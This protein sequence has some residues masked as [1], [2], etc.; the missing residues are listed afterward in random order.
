MELFNQCSY[1]NQHIKFICV[2]F[3]FTNFILIPIYCIGGT[4]GIWQMIGWCNF[5]W[6]VLAIAL[7]LTYGF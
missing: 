5:I 2:C 4:K 1:L 6:I 7:I 3:A